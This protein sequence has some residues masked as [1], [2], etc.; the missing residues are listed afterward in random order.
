MSKIFIDPSLNYIPQ[1]DFAATSTENGGVEATQTFLARKSDV[2][3]GGAALIG[4]NRGERLQI[5]DPKCT[6]LYGN[7]TLKSAEVRDYAPGVSAIIATFTGYSTGNNADSA[8]EETSFPTSSLVGNIEDVPLSEMAKWKALSEDEQ[9]ML[10]GL[11]S[12]SLMYRR[13]PYSD[14]E[15]YVLTEGEMILPDSQQIT[16]EDGLRFARMIAAGKVSYKKGS[17]V[18]TYR[19][20]SKTGFKPSQLNSLGKIVANPPGDPVKPSSG[21]TWLLAS[22]NQEQSGPDRF[23]KSLDFLLIEDNEDNQFLYS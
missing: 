18:Y 15:D 3:R 19:T 17:W 10:G 4:F 14:G 7:L 1:M 22:P 11:L 16:S 9:N 5:L 8:G 2:A 6:P 13:D 21:W 12:G 20:E 23:I